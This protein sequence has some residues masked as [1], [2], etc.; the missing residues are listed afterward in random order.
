[1]STPFK[2]KNSSLMMNAKSG[3]PINYG[4]PLEKEKKE[5]GSKRTQTTVQNRDAD[6]NV[7]QGFTEVSKNKSGNKVFT[8]NTGAYTVDGVEQ[9]IAEKKTSN[10]SGNRG[11]V[12]SYDSKNKTKTKTN[13]RTGKV[14]T[15][16]KPLSKRDKRKVS[17]IILK[18][19]QGTKS[20]S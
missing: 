4:S 19:K 5:K 13:L 12:V 10:R 3:T 2:M 6:G 1:M 9:S 20:E 15:T 8:S 7:I 16:V 14:T 18:S 11:K 17:K